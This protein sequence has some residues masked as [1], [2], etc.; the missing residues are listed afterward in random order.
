MKKI[1]YIFFI[2]LSLNSFSQSTIDLKGRV[3]EVGTDEPLAGTYVNFGK[4]VKP[5]IVDENGDFHVFLLEGE[6]DVV[7]KLVGYKNLNQRIQINS[8]SSP[9]IPVN[10]SAT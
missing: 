6:Y 3:L 1:L 2:L 8:T 10:G 9:L 4:S 7:V 5:I